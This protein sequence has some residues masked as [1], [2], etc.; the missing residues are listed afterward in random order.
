MKNFIAL[1]FIAF[2]A[3]TSVAVASDEAWNPYTPMPHDIVI[4]KSDAPITIVEYASLT[5]PHC[6]RFHRETIPSLKEQLIE[7]GQAKLIYRHMPLD[8]S[9]LAGALASSCAPEDIRFDVVSTL[10][11]EVSVWAPDITQMVPVLQKKFGDKL[12]AVETLKCASS[13][14]ISNVIVKG[15]TNAID[16]G[17][18]STPT[19]FMNGE[20]FEG[21]IAPENFL[22]LAKGKSDN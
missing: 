13:S 8:Q 19:F 10:F 7:T 18:A 11:E 15:M 4:G 9:A 17:V 2:A 5:C 6:G 22:P 20:K 1:F 12:D 21:F 14:E 3:F 16:N